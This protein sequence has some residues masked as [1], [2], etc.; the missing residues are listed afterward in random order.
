MA[1]DEPFEVHSIA[2]CESQIGGPRDVFSGLRGP[3]RLR[4]KQEAPWT[5][6]SCLESVVLPCKDLPRRWSCIVRRLECRCVVSVHRP[7]VPT[8]RDQEVAENQ[9]LRAKWI[10]DEQQRFAPCPSRP[11][12]MV[13]HRCLSA[14]HPS[15]QADVV[16]PFRYGHL[17]FGRE[18][19]AM[20]EANA[21][22]VISQVDATSLRAQ[23][24][25]SFGF[26]S[27]IGATL[28]R[29]DTP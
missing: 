17:Q 14:L 5:R 22:L 23:R 26:C 7:G 15:C 28:E 4:H 27:C 25:I 19:P 11:L 24:H 21:G 13:S 2:R 12:V 16:N 1:S 29:A 20:Q 18:P 6:E 3:S 9:R 8:Q 10:V